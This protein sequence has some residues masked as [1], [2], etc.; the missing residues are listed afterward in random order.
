MPVRFLGSAVV[1][2]MVALARTCAATTYSVVDLGTVSGYDARTLP[3]AIN[4]SGQIVGT[5]YTSTDPTSTYHAF[6]YSAG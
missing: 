2:A 6:S 4:N 1:L 5:S 3:A